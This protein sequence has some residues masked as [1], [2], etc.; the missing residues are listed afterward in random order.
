LTSAKQATGI[1]KVID[2][3]ETTRKE[4]EAHKY[5]PKIYVIGSTNVGKSTFINA[6]IYRTN[7]YKD[8]NKML[9]RT[10]FDILTES[11]MPGTTLDF[12]H[13]EALKVGFKVFDTPGIPNTQSSVA[14]R[15]ADY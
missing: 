7:R 4:L 10:K 14:A 8:P 9:Y 6:M 12:V 15:I 3:L 11:P 2:I 13:V 5:L 1:K